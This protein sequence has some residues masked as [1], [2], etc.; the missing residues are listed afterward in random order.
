MTTD[1]IAAPGITTAT[2]VAGNA[3]QVVLTLS[4]G[5][6]GLALQALNALETGGFG[7][8]MSVGGTVTAAVGASLVDGTH[9]LLTF[10]APVPTDGS[11]TI[12]Y[13]PNAL[14]PGLAGVDASGGTIDAA[15]IL[16]AL[17]QEIV[18]QGKSILTGVPVPSITTIE[19]Q[20]DQLLT[21]SGSLPVAPDPSS[22]QTVTAGAGQESVMAGAAADTITAGSTNVVAF[23]GQGGITFVGGSSDNTVVVGA[24]ASTVD[25]KAG[26][27]TV[28][29][30][31]GGGVFTGG[32]AG[33]NILVGGEGAATL[34]GAGSGDQLFVNGSQH[35]VLQAG[36]GNETLSAGGSAG[37]NTITGGSGSDLVAGGYGTDQIDA[38]SGSST[39]F[40]GPGSDTINTGAG[41]TMVA[42]GANGSTIVGGNGNSTV[43]GGIGANVINTGAG[44]MLIDGG[45]GAETVNFG[46]GNAVVFEH[47]GATTYTATNGSVGG[48]DLI[49]GF[50]PA[51]DTIR[52]SGYG[53]AATIAG[54][55]TNAGGTSIVHLSDGT[56]LVFFGVS[57]IAKNIVAS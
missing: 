6:G 16:G 3:N 18:D 44:R 30:G 40:G 7:W 42:A 48:L 52:L 54:E 49:V 56:Q 28:F 21:L 47:G 22:T 25:G 1:P 57:D 50:K 27:V 35:N 31:Q 32:S 12:A 34:V 46:A 45:S 33:N 4:L 15:S 55:T 5:S 38:G 11:A 10:A 26:A 37:A 43:F 8:S 23:G 29:G 19:N 36:N 14:P 13:N 24:G 39:I 41:Q 17:Q 20:Q 51:A 2:A 9:L 53:S